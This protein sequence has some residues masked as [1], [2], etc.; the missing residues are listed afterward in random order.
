M[1]ETIETMAARVA[2]RFGERLQRVE[3]GCGELT[4]EVPK[5]DL[6]EVAVA[7]RDDEELRLRSTHGRL[8]RGLPHLRRGRVDHVQRHGV[9]F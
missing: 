2:T 8:R 4:F 5:D 9:G 7:L 1:G 3:S 6:L